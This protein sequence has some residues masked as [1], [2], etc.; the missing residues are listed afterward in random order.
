MKNINCN[1]I[2]NDIEKCDIC[3]ICLDTVNYKT[4]KK[5]KCKNSCRNLMHIECY[6]ALPE[7]KCLICKEYFNIECNINVNVI[8]R[9]NISKK[10]KC[11]LCSSGTCLFSSL[12]GLIIHA[13]YIINK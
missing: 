8:N 4:L 6:N 10:M 2:E 12:V 3:M 13:V 11:I 9:Y 1:N 5:I 7:K